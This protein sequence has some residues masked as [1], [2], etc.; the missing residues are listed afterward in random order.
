MRSSEHRKAKSR[1]EALALLSIIKERAVPIKSVIQCGLGDWAEG[2]VMLDL[3]SH[4]SFLAV[5]PIHRYCFES[6][7][8]GY[9]GPIIQGLLWNETGLTKE[10]HDHR[11]RT[12]VHD[13]KPHGL[14]SLIAKTVTLDDAV[15]W[16]K[17][18]AEDVLLWMDCEGSELEILKGAKATLLHTNAI[19]CELKRRDRH[20]S[21]PD[22][23]EAIS[24]LDSL[25]YE[26]VDKM[27]T[28]GLFLR[29]QSTDAA[30][31]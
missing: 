10:L 3:F 31:G 1:K 2:P 28:D 22:A 11:T 12:S 8:A 16:T 25:G 14:G 20:P 5:E 4:A 26:M 9:R 30:R 13:D 23:E 27:R 21:W 7:A 24:V 6:W 15:T 19:I 29:K 17:F 18:Q